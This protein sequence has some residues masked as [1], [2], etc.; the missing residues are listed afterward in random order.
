MGFAENISVAMSQNTALAGR[1]HDFKAQQGKSSLL[2]KLG[3]L[4]QAAE[5][6]KK[7]PS[8]HSAPLAAVGGSMLPGAPAA[9]TEVPSS[10]GLP[11][12]SGE[13]SGVLEAVAGAAGLIG[14]DLG[15]GG[16]NPPV[17]DNIAGAGGGG[18]L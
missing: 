1:D 9:G 5:A 6:E 3:R 14:A 4:E 17:E 11:E 8:L 7:L 13:G 12:M 10:S 16:E 15:N 2:T 18:P